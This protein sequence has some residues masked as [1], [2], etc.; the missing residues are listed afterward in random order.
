MNRLGAISWN[1]RDALNMSMVGDGLYSENLAF[2]ASRWN[3]LRS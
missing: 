2:L 1:K 3:R